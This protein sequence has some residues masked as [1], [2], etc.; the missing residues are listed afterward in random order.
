MALVQRVAVQASASH[1]LGALQIKF[2][3]SNLNSFGYNV[4]LQSHNNLVVTF[5]KAPSWTQSPRCPWRWWPLAQHAGTR[6]GHGHSPPRAEDRRSGQQQKKQALVIAT[7]IRRIAK[8]GAHLFLEWG[9]T[10]R[11]SQAATRGIT[12]HH[13]ASREQINDTH[14]LKQQLIADLSNRVAAHQLKP[15][16]AAQILMVPRPRVSDVVNQKTAKF[17]IDTLVGMLS[18]AGKPLHW[19]VV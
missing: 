12:R 9:F 17:T 8:A 14:L 5:N 19:V 4:T 3:S 18:R 11:T 1:G 2:E 13:A 15:A 6:Q 16:D 7:E 10:T